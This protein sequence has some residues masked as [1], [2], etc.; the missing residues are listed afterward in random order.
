MTSTDHEQPLHL[1]SLPDEILVRILQSLDP[2]CLARVARC[3]RQL[4]R[5][6]MDNLVWS[7][8]YD[9]ALTV[10]ST[11]T[12]TPA[13]A[14][15]ANPMNSSSTTN[16]AVRVENRAETRSNRSN[17]KS[18]ERRL[19]Q[20]SPAHGTIDWRS[21][22]IWMFGTFSSKELV[23]HTDAVLQLG[24]QRKSEQAD[25]D[26]PDS[27]DDDE[28]MS[29]NNSFND[30]DNDKE[31]EFDSRSSELLLSGSADG[32]IRVWDALSGV[33]RRTI[34]IPTPR[35]PAAMRFSDRLDSACVGGETGELAVVD[36]EAGQTVTS[37]SL[38]RASATQGTR[39]PTVTS[40]CMLN[41]TTLIAGL[42]SGAVVLWDTR[43]HCSQ[44]HATQLLLRHEGSVL[45]V[46]PA[47]THNSSQQ[48][49]SYEL[50]NE[51]VT[52]SRDTTVRVFD[53]R[54]NRMRAAVRTGFIVRDTAFLDTGRL[55]VTGGPYLSRGASDVVALDFY[56]YATMS[57][58][59]R[60]KDVCARSSAAISSLSVDSKT[61]CLLTSS[62]SGGIGLWNIATGASMRSVVLPKP[63][64]GGEND[65]LSLANLALGPQRIFRGQ[66]DGT[67]QVFSPSL[68]LPPV[69]LPGA[70]FAA[71]MSDSVY[72][73]ELRDM[74]ASRFG[75]SS[76]T[77]NSRLSGMF[78]R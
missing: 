55:A 30:N 34:D 33:C 37:G 36:V 19:S 70:F 3:C 53:V 10:A 52:G 38:A 78:P 16:A 40:I 2:P 65:T 20:A 50:P 72:S 73:D 64:Q 27:D 45:S 51:L 75:S 74:V 26:N 5:L 1:L 71:N 18:A 29:L 48:S 35:Q 42:V 21:R 11:R 49:Y 57:R 8:V 24:F 47:P 61:N 9:R 17:P 32:T 63:Q 76:V 41:R 54:A 7:K 12:S 31:L 62:W 6:A 22:Y 68:T 60:A 43:S 28:E 69:A 14:S 77:I 67:I 13:A 56:D 44:A 58:V 25:S 46:K 4:R 39:T 23:G 59:A 15:N 66:L